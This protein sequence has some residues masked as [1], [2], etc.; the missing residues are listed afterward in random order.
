M[1]DHKTDVAIVGG[2]PAGMLLGLLLSQHGV[3]TLVLERHADFAREYRGEVLMPRF[4]QMMKEIGLFDTLLKYPHLKLNGFEFYVG[5]RHV[6]SI[7]ISKLAPESPFILWMPQP[8]MLNALYQK[9]KESAAFDLWF[10]AD[11][12][13]LTEENHQTTGLVVKTK[14]RTLQVGA[15]VI[16]GADGRNSLIRRKGGFDLAYEDHDFDILWFTISKPEGFENNVRGFISLRHNY[17]ILP[18]LPHH[19]QCGIMIEKNSYAKIKNAG[20]ADL[21]K[22]LLAAHP[23]F[24]DFATHLEDFHAFTLL[25]AKADR[26]REWA[27]DGLLLIGDAAHTCSPAGA[28]GVS[29][30]VGTAIVASDVILKCVKAG[31]FSKSALSEVQ[32]RREPDVKE[33]QSIQNRAA[34]LVK[35]QPLLLKLLALIAIILLAKTPIFRRT[36]RR[37]LLMNKP[38]LNREKVSGMA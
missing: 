6:T 22:E 24:K 18:K 30:A 34:A 10:Q 36:Q 32:K 29:V 11:A 19:L 13:D 23:V 35:P 16:V 33:I 37:L 26:V 7:D 20:I 15:K 21:K 5:G 27:K 28:I 38:L 31:N 17:L 9:A 3:K 4:M 8:V 12:L 25:P 2:G 14:D 1:M